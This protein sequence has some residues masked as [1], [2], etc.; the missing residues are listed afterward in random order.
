MPRYKEIYT[1][2]VFNYDRLVS[3]ED[4]QGHILKALNEIRQLH[5]ASVVEFGAGT[6]RLTALLAPLVNEVHAF[7]AYPAML[8]LA[9]DKF[10][11]MGIQNVRFEVAENKS[12]PVESGSYDLSIAGWTLGHCTSWFEETWK[13]EISAA[14]NEML[15]VLKPNGTAVILETLGTG[16]ERP[17][18][19]SKAL[20]DYYHFLEEAFDFKRSWIRTDYKFASL[21]EAKEL[22]QAFFG[23]TFDFVTLPTGEVCLPECTGIWSRPL[24]R[25]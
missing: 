3:K 25:A 2:Q 4:Y 11:A 7:D 10:Q 20:A 15:R 21:E 9:R 17:E 13:V 12:L 23:T 8:N 16:R 5:G 6:G 18:P 1:N 19:P 22:T 14:V 24:T